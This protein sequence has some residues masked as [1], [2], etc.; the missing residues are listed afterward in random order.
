VITNQSGI[1]RGFYSE[2]TL[3][4][5]HHHLSQSLARDQAVLDAIY[6]C[7]HHPRAGDHR[8]RR[9]CQCRKPAPG[10]LHQ[11]AIDHRIDL[12]RSWVIGDKASDMHLARAAGARAALVRTGY[13][14]ETLARPDE[15]PCEME[16]VAD[17]LLEAVRAILTRG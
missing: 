4:A 3:D 14:S 2:E 8:Y 15:W 1:A 10:L 17:N 6:Y 7:P 12:A 9:E 11:A 13:G 16:I 5:I